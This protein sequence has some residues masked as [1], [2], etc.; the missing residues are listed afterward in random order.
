VWFSAHTVHGD[1]TGAVHMLSV[2]TEIRIPDE[3]TLYGLLDDGLVRLTDAAV[4]C[5]HCMLHRA[6]N[7]L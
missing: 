5:M 4:A 2:G 6:S 3:C 1:Q 7:V